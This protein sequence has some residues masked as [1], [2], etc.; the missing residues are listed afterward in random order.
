MRTVFKILFV[1]VVVNSCD[2]QSNPFVGD[3]P[4]L[5]IE[6]MYGESRDI[7]ILNNYSIDCDQFDLDE[8]VCTE[9][10]WCSYEEGD[11]KS[12]NK[13]ILIVANQ[14]SEGLVIYEIDDSDIIQLSEIYSDNGFEV[15]D[16]ISLV[17][18]L[19]LRKLVYSED[20]Q[21]LYMLDKF[22]YVYTAWL[23]GL[24]DQ[25]SC[26]IS[27]SPYQ[28]RP[29]DGVSNYHTTQV[30]LDERNLDNMEN[31]LLL[32]KYN[33]NNISQQN[34]EGLASSTTSCSKLGVN[35]LDSFLSS[36]LSC[37]SVLLNGYME[38][39]PFSS[40][41]FDYNIYDIHFEDEQIYIANPYDS[42]VFK[43]SDSHVLDVNY[44]PSTFDITEGCD[45]P[46]N[47][48]SLTESG[49]VI[50]N[51]DSDI[52]YFEFN[53]YNESFNEGG[54]GVMESYETNDAC[55]FDANNYFI[56]C[57]T[58]Y[59]ELQN[60]Q[61][62][63]INFGYSGTGNVCN[64]DPEIAEC[65]G[66]VYNFNLEDDIHDLKFEIMISGNKL[67]GNLLG[68]SISTPEKCGTL[69]TLDKFNNG[70]LNLFNDDF[71]SISIYNLVEPSGVIDFYKNLKTNS[72]VKTI[73]KYNE[74]LITGRIDD[75]CYITLLNESRNSIDGMPILGSE[76][77]TVNDI[78]Y[79][80]DNDLLLLSC[81]NK[82]VLV[83]SWNGI[84]DNALFLKH[85]VSSHAY[86]AKVYKDSYIIIATK[87][88][89][90]IYNYEIN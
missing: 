25:Y 72:K 4:I 13:D 20:T 64:W 54:V 1:I 75:G 59:C 88:G 61:N 41:L 38:F 86:S 2:K 73:Y 40:P 63:C 81:G 3:D 11:C 56:K 67:I 78:Y 9:N 47:S 51:I 16:N 89:V 19:E 44:Y 57:L 24:L 50:Y 90:E 27:L 48:I 10:I 87:Y 7:L 49:E 55:E 69:V 77:F 60:N 8:V 18:D 31:V 83:Y 5:N 37:E 33:A 30:V 43:D 17:N 32:F 46:R 74:F 68:D 85:I 35:S 52:G 12:E 36:D 71:H 58:Q 45:L 62:D 26:D 82:G 70:E 42:F 23:P 28:L 14:Y 53:F 66:Q 39:Y 29:Y 34:L 22:E 80:D 65:T 84:S 6:N 15:L 76:N 21:F 79:D